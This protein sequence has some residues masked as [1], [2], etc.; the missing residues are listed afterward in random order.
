M[1]LHK[2]ALIRYRI[3]DSLLK[4][5]YKPYP[6]IE[7]L[8]AKCEEDLFGSEG[9]QHISMSTIE[10]DLRAMR[11][12]VSLGFEAPIKYSRVHK[13]YHYTD[14]EYTIQNIPLNNED[15]D[16]IKLAANTLFNFRE[17]PLFS[18]FKFAIEKIFDRL[19]IA[20]E[21]Q[22]DRLKNLV[23]FDS[24]PDYPGNE[25]LADIYNAITKNLSIELTYQ[26]FNSNEPTVRQ[27]DPYLLKEYQYRWY[28]IGY[29]KEKNKIITYAL[30][31]IKSISVLELAFDV[32]EGFSPDDFFKYSFGITESKT[33]PSD[34]IL[35]F[36]L[37]QLGYMQTKTL[38]DSQ[39]ITLFKNHFELSL[40][41]VPSFELYEKLLSYGARVEV[42]HPEE[43]REKVK[44]LC[45]AANSLYKV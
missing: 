25:Y 20:D 6:D 23:Q 27:L 16:A 22:D 26:K 5:K 7:K 31:R 37:N 8:R 42:L 2:Y 1:S 35:K 43:V 21:V 33:K 4:N 38:H 36:D 29:S 14:P 11:E 12:D 9:G 41:L 40:Q 30:D 17:S 3:I 13:G 44:E 34:I 32:I 39:S 10:K 19:N 18:Q 45:E 24:Y 15:V 28:V